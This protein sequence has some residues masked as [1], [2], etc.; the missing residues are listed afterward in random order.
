MPKQS[1]AVKL[2]IRFDD[3]R[4]TIVIN[5]AYSFNDII[6][7]LKKTQYIEETCNILKVYL[8]GI[9]SFYE[10]G[11]SDP[12]MNM[13]LTE[14]EKTIQKYTDERFPNHDFIYHEEFEIC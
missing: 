8:V 2:I 1:N 13:N 12:I 3:F 14:F 11:F 9:R 5:G 7:Y 6:N 10:I 4:N